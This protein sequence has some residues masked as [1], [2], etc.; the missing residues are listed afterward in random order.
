MKLAEH[1]LQTQQSVLNQT[2]TARPAP[3]RRRLRS[4]CGCPHRELSPMALHRRRCT[5]SIP[6]PPHSINAIKRGQN[7]MNSNV[8]KLPATKSVNMSP[9]CSPTKRASNPM[10]DTPFDPQPERPPKTGDPPCI[11]IIHRTSIRHNQP[12]G[13]YRRIPLPRS[14]PSVQ[15]TTAGRSNT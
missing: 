7:E 11:P 5:P 1:S 12:R 3:Q 4:E 9:R 15:R 8:T 2:C 14:R 6:E 13:G 10:A